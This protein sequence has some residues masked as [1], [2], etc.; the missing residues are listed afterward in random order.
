MDETCDTPDDYTYFQA[1]KD[2]TPILEP[3]W[4]LSQAR[5]MR[6]AVVNK[7]YCTDVYSHCENGLVRCCLYTSRRLYFPF[8]ASILS[9][10]LFTLECQILCTCFICF[11]PLIPLVKKILVPDIKWSFF[12]VTNVEVTQND[13]HTSRICKPVRVNKIQSATELP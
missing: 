5:A 3:C 6:S 7:L 4:P 9:D 2:D 1:H 10:F 13:A 11:V 8:V 12:R